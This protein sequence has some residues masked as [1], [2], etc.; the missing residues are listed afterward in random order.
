MAKILVVE[1]DK[2]LAENI[3]DWLKHESY[4]V[5]VAHTAELASELLATFFY[6]LLVLDWNLPGASGVEL[7]KMYRAGGGL[8]S[9]LMI[10]GKETVKDKEIGLDA[11]ADDYL[12]KPFHLRELSARVR[13]LLRRPRNALATVLSAGDISLDSAT[14]QVKKGEQVIDLM[15]KEYALLEFFLRHPNQV[16]DQDAII[17]HLWHSEKGVGI[18][19]VRTNI[20]R[21]RKKIDGDSEDSLIKNL[22]GQGYKLEWPIK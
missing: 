15:P 3:E 22:R 20:M 7:V 5:E 16:F 18:E 21:L 13:A 17:D 4:T 6:D 14:R 19:T 9:V 10:T 11:G 2:D 1:D 8:T 12:T